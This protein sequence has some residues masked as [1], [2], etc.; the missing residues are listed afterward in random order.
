[1]GFWNDRKDWFDQLGSCSFGLSRAVMTPLMQ[2]SRLT[3][4]KVLCI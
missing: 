1:M 2:G 4:L 3:C